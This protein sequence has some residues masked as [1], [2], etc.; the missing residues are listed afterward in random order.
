MALALAREKLNYGPEQ[1]EDMARNLRL[2]DF[3]PIL[4]IYEEDIKSPV[5]SALAGTLLRSVFI[6]LQK[7]KV[8][9]DD[10]LV[11]PV[12]DG[13]L[14][15]RHRSSAFWNRQT[16]EVPRVNI[17]ICWCSPGPHDCVCHGWLPQELV[18]WW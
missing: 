6:Q 4:K 18:E 1:L 10:I 16:A 8:V 12:A 3:T 13:L 2:G 7:A 5:K 14:S 15:V 17:R 9:V 11:N